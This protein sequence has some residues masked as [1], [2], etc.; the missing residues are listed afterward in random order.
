MTTHPTLQLKVKIK[1]CD[2]LL[3]EKATVKPGI[4]CIRIPLRVHQVLLALEDRRVLSSFAERN[5]NKLLHNTFV[6][7][8][9]EEKIADL[10]F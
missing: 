2:L 10:I 7:L 1:Y 8:K 3:Y 6:H 4:L 9:I 5:A